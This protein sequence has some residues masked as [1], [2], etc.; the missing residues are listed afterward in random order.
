MARNETPHGTEAGVG[1]SKQ[2]EAVPVG[3]KTHHNQQPTKVKKMEGNGKDM[4]TCPADEI[5]SE[6]KQ[7]MDETGHTQS[8]GN[9]GINVAHINGCITL[10]RRKGATHYAGV[11]VVEDMEAGKSRNTVQVRNAV[12][13]SRM[14]YAVHCFAHGTQK[15]VPSRG[16][17]MASVRLA[18]KAYEGNSPLKK[19]AVQQWCGRC[20]KDWESQQGA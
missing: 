16:A 9:R 5:Q 11:F 13:N 3:V 6:M 2:G 18:G 12:R 4:T 7:W 17:G 19:G 8:H 1:V 15:P 14:K 20:V 10:K